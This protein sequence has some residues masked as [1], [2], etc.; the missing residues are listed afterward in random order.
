MATV[1]VL[2]RCPLWFLAAKGEKQESPQSHRKLL[3]SWVQRLF[4]LDY[5]NL[6]YVGLLLKMT[7][8]QQGCHLAAHLL[9]SEN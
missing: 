6:H 4:C 5:F 7:G 1:I 9:T 8:L 2:S 3:I